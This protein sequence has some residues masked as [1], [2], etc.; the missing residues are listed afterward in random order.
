M[1]HNNVHHWI[2]EIVNEDVLLS[3]WGPCKR[4][5]SVPH[6][7]EHHL[8]ILVLKTNTRNFCIDLV[9]IS[10]TCKVMTMCEKIDFCKTLMTPFPNMWTVDLTWPYPSTYWLGYQW[11]SFI[12]P[13]L[14][15]Y[16]MYQVRSFWSKAFLS[17]QLHKVLVTDMNFDL[18]RWHTDLNIKWIRIIYSSTTIYLPSLKLLG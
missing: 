6:L 2:L 9:T 14:S 5:S 10:S 4:L 3:I 17:Y 18:D 7:K 1:I 13:K 11:G 12:H 8:P 15:T 16:I